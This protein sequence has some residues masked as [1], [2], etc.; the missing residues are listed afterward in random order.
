MPRDVFGQG[1]EGQ[2]LNGGWTT[3]CDER[4]R[5]RRAALSWKF[6]LQQAGGPRLPSWL[7]VLLQPFL[8]KPRP[9]RA[10]HLQMPRSMGHRQGQ[11]HPLM[12]RTPV[13]VLEGPRAAKP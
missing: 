5:T 4:P 2:V 10:E 12:G 9:G 1:Q 6:S 8:L 11:E 7:P 3:Q 13:S